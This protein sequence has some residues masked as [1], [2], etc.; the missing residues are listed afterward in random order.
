[1]QLCLIFLWMIIYF[2]AFGH[3]N[4]ADYMSFRHHNLQLKGGT[5]CCPLFCT[6]KCRLQKDF[7]WRKCFPSE[8]VQHDESQIY[9]PFYAICKAGGWG[10]ALYF[11]IPLLNPFEL[12]SHSNISF[13]AMEWYAIYVL[14]DWK[15]CKS[16][17]TSGQFGPIFRFRNICIFNTWNQIDEFI[18]ERC[19]PLPSLVQV[20]ATAVLLNFKL[21]CFLHD[22]PI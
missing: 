18:T 4:H 19:T 9:R 21:W 20:D 15:G 8:I 7:P 3:T 14:D 11:F 1:M 6:G 16:Q 10:E 2:F 22:F 12:R 17:T 5:F 13:L